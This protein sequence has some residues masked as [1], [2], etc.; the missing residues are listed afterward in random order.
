MNKLSDSAI[1]PQDVPPKFFAQHFKPYEFLSGFVRNKIVLE[2]GC[3]DGYGADY[4]SR[5]AKRIIAI[6]HSKDNI[7]HAESR[8]KKENLKFKVMQALELDFPD[9]SFDVAYSFQ[10]IEH[11]P[12]S[13]L[14]QY[15]T[16]IKRVLAQD[17]LACFSTLNLRHGMKPGTIYKKN[18]DH[19]K[20]FRFSELKDL[21]SKVFGSVK[22][23]VGDFTLSL[24]HLPKA[25][26]FICICS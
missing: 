10:V 18:P 12:E 13:K 3:G 2:I 4:L 15:L 7:G 24:K 8:Y 25:I 11:I 21:L 1:V 9:K 20:E 16:E 17:G 14:V 19:C 5:Y 26:D 23:Y 6:D 22:I